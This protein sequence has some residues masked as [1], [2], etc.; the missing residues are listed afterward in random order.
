MKF[1]SRIY[2]ISKFDNR[3]VNVVSRI[4]NIDFIVGKRMERVVNFIIDSTLVIRL[5]KVI[6][7]LFNSYYGVF[8][9][10]IVFVLVGELD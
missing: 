3:N 8:D 1:Y 7:F 4:Y 10:N 6:N 5:R 2:I 9:I